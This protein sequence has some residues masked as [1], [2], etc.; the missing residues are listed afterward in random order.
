MKSGKNKLVKETTFQKHDPPS[1]VSIASPDRLGTRAPGIIKT[2]AQGV[3][4][5][6]TSSSAKSFLKFLSKK[7]DLPTRRRDPEL[8]GVH[9]AG[10]ALGLTGSAFEEAGLNSPSSPPA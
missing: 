2:R 6:D 7:E 3:N 8:R 1:M 10:A 5:K 4:H 9:F